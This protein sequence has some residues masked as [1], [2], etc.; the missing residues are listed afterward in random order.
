MDIVFE[1][2]GTPYPIVSPYGIRED[3]KNNKGK[4]VRDCLDLFFL[5]YHYI[6]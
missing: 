2:P 4:V 6:K 5:F 1:D 3:E